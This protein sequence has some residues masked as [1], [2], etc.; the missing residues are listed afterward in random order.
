MRTLQYETAAELILELL[1]EV[2]KGWKDRSD[3]EQRFDEIRARD[4]C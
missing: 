3:L 4:K 2:P 1:T